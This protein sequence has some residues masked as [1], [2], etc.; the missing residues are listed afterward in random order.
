MKR[1]ITLLLIAGGITFSGTATAQV[2]TAPEP[3]TTDTTQSAKKVDKEKGK[4]ADITIDESGTSQPRKKRNA[5]KSAPK[6]ADSSNRNSRK[7]E[8]GATPSP[9]PE[10][11]IAID[12]SGTSKPKPK[13]K[14]NPGATPTNNSDSTI[15]A[16]A[17]Q[18]GRPE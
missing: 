1:F 8:Q 16:P 2:K 9:A 5:T 10:N 3:K 4:S 13:S 17:V 18:V 15:V 12:E 11:E 14:G 7:Q 6:K